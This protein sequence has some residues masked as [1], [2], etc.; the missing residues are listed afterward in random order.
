MTDLEGSVLFV[1]G[2]ELRAEGAVGELASRGAQ[3]TKAQADVAQLTFQLELA[4]LELLDALR[5][6]AA[7]EILEEIFQMDGLRED[8]EPAF[9]TRLQVRAVLLGDELSAGLAAIADEQELR[10]AG[11]ACGDVV[12]LDGVPGAAAK[13]AAAGR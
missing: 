2:D 3:A 10:A 7:L 4:A 6:R 5:C 13:T 9:G 12:Q 8:L 1:A 11:G